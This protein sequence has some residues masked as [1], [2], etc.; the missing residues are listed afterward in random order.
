MSANSFNTFPSS[1]FPHIPTLLYRTSS[2][3]SQPLSRLSSY[4]HSPLST[5]INLYT[6]KTLQEYQG[7]IYINKRDY[8]FH[9]HLFRKKFIYTQI[10]FLQIV[11][12]IT[13]LTYSHSSDAICRLQIDCFFLTIIARVILSKKS[14]PQKSFLKRITFT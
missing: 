5:Y 1:I 7:N 14:R 6:F 11:I 4:L 10:Y 9:V 13:L 12:D 2:F 3:P 8:E